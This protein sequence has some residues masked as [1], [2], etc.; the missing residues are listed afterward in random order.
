MG[1]YFCATCECA[2]ICAECI[3][4]GAH[5]G[6]DVLR[7]G[8]AHEALRA[9]AGTLLDEALALEDEFAVVT[10]KLTWRRKEIERAAAR[11]RASVRSAFARVRAQ[12]ADRE[13]EL[14]DSLDTYERD[15]M[16]RLEKG[17]G[18][19]EQ[20]LGELRKLQESLRARCRSGD[21]VEALN[22]Y[23]SAKSAIESLR[24]TFRREEVSIAGPPEEFIGLAGSAR[25]EID[26]HAEGLAS[27]EEAVASLCERGAEFQN[28]AVPRIGAA[29][30][31]G[32]V[33]RSPD[34]AI[35]VNPVPW[36]S[37]GQR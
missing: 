17:A 19:H 37:T 21:A 18:D 30:G 34:A 15:T 28:Q 2:C 26:L 20:R 9:R 13:T 31:G 32:V 3:V 29:A 11:G 4:H 1:T 8:K 12:L 23:A 33:R 24:E 7:V 36:V 16:Q 25:A 35:G 10:D 5:R 27:L 22:A 14:L 6:H